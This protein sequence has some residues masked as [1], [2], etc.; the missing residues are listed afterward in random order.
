MAKIGETVHWDEGRMVVQETHDWN[1]ILNRVKALK[2]AGVDGLGKENKLVARV[3]MKLVHEWAKKWGVSMSDT[4][5][6]EE[7][8][9]R[10]LQDRDNAQ[11]RVW[12]GS[13]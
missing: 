8:V 10:E 3:P 1:P 13:F 2:S 7:V 9:A 4:K 12:E 11:F 6:M 5:A